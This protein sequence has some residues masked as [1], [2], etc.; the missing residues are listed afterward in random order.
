MSVKVTERERRCAE[1]IMTKLVCQNM[2]FFDY[3]WSSKIIATEV[4]EP[5]REL[6]KQVRS[7]PI[8]EGWSDYEEYVEWGK[9]V[10]ALLE[11]R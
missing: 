7:K 6:L 4:S 5:Y 3:E 2:S 11:E 9:K 10:D 8:G 1:K